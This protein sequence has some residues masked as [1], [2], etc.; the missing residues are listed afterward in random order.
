MSEPRVES[1]FC[2]EVK[3]LYINSDVKVLI[4]AKDKGTIEEFTKE[5]NKLTNY[6]KTENTK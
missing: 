4:T 5:L 6:L 2:S 3:F 1:L